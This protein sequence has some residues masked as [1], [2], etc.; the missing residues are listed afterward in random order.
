MDEEEDGEDDDDDPDEWK[1]L[2]LEITDRVMEVGCLPESCTGLRATA[3]FTTVRFDRSYGP[4]RPVLLGG[5]G[6]S[7]TRST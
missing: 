1:A 5:R 2:P 7:F 6:S 4:R 3:T